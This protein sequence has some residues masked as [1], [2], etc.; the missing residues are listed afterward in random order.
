MSYLNVVEISKNFGSLN[1]FSK[2]SFQVKKGEFVT[3][4]GPSGCG[5]STAL[6]CIAG[7]ADIEAGEILIEDQKIDHLRVQQRNV[8][9]VF[10][11]YAL[12]PN[13]SV[14]ENI[15]FGLKMKKVSRDKRKER[16]AEMISMVELD[17]RE[18]HYVHQLSGG[19]QQRVA[20]AR[21]L[22][23]QPRILLLDEP[24]SALDARIRRSLR[25]K[26]REIQKKLGLTTILVTHDQ[27]EA[28][29]VSDNIFIMESGK[30]AQSGTPE[31]IYTSPKN[32]FVAGFLGNCNLFSGQD[33]SNLSGIAFSSEIYAVRPEAIT[34]L[35]DTTGPVDS[36][37]INLVG[38]VEDLLVLGNI[39]RYSI[40]VNGSTVAVDVLNKNRNSW[41]GIGNKVI[42]HIPGDGLMALEI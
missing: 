38:N 40:N 15:E 8:G 25:I 23:V 9:M 26:I 17:G 7:L 18:K 32:K 34:I 21:A 14:E 3:L 16:V 1:V 6:R 36:D 2:L 5:K 24:L 30:I 35:C 37:G 42:L 39:L 12:F 13:L 28:L 10:Q 41:H 22:V 19:Q 11:S 27:E 20:L 31:E 29:T 33:I 4:L